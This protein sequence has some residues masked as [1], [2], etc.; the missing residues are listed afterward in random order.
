MPGKIGI[1]WLFLCE[2]INDK[3]YL[4]FLLIHKERDNSRR[5]QNEEG[6]LIDYCKI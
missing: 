2:L 1:L 6:I 4:T 5:L 3:T